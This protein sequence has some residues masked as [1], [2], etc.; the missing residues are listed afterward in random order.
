[1]PW[2]PPQQTT[3]TTATTTTTNDF[4]NMTESQIVLL[5][6]THGVTS[7]RGLERGAE[8]NEVKS[9]LGAQ[10]DMKRS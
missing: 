6:T 9:Q 4:V 5:Q 7:M 2:F 3:H 1:M 10:T 8:R